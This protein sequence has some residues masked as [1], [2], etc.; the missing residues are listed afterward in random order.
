MSLSVK[1]KSCYISQ[2]LDEAIVSLGAICKSINVK[3]KKEKVPQRERKEL[4]YQTNE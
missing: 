1:E 3:E 2:Y 4:R